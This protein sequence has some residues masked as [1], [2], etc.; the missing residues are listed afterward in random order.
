MTTK[1]A[2]LESGVPFA[3]PAHRHRRC[4]RQR[5]LDTLGYASLDDLLADAVPAS[6]REKLA[7]ALP[8]AATEAAGRRRAARARGP[9][10]RADLDDR[11]RLLRHRHARGD[12]P[13]RAGE[14]GLVHR[15]HARTSPRS[16]RGGSRRCST[17]RPSSRTSP[18]CRWRAP[19]CST[20]APRPPRP[21]RSHTARARA[22]SF[23]VDA[24]VLPQTLDVV[25][26]RA[27]PLGLEVVVHDLDEPLPDGDLFGVLVQ[28]PGASGAI[29]DLAP[30]AEA[31][32]DARRAARRGRRPAGPDAD[33]RAG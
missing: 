10:R 18:G 23:V 8:P 28:Y 25:R 13:Q 24:D 17:S 26:T 19:R 11:P 33:H 20:R 21:W 5:M 29:R 3:E 14:P 9:Q 6:I 7:L 30:L 27:L 16:A 15:L 2:D 32:H 12:P 22:R 4:R 31:A 1:L